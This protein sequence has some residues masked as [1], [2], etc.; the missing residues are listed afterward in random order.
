[1]NLKSLKIKPLIL[2][3]ILFH[4]A[5]A[6]ASWF[7]FYLSAKNPELIYHSLKSYFIP[8]DI[9]S[10]LAK[11]NWAELLDNPYWHISFKQLKINKFLKVFQELAHWFIILV[12]IT[13]LYL[14]FN[15]KRSQDNSI[16]S[17]RFKEIFIYAT[18]FSLIGVFS[19]PND[20]SD[21]YGY[22]ARGA[23]Q[24]F[25]G[26]NPYQSVAADIND[27]QNDSFLGNM[28]WEKNPA[29]Y[30]PLFIF[31]CKLIVSL[32]FNNF[33]LAIFLF[34]LISSGCFLGT[35]FFIK[36]IFKLENLHDRPKLFNTFEPSLVISFIALNPFLFYHSSWNG[37]NDIVMVFLFIASIYSL[38]K[39]R[40]NLALLLISA[41]IFIKYIAIVL[42]PL[43]I[44]YIWKDY[45]FID[46]TQKTPLSFRNLLKYLVPLGS[47]VSL[48]FAFLLF[49]YYD[50]FSSNFSAINQN[51]TLSHKSLF[52]TLETIYKA[53]TS[54][55]LAQIIKY[56][57]LS[58]FAAFAS[59]IYIKFWTK[60]YSKDLEISME[61][62]D[63]RNRRLNYAFLESSTFILAALVLVASPKFHSWYLVI[64]LA[65]GF[66]SFPELAVIFSI[67]HL[68]SFTFI[69]QANIL[70][71][72]L[73]TVLPS[74]F[75]F[76]KSLQ[77]TKV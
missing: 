54:N 71:Y 34:K 46:K 18:V 7:V 77:N 38:F 26:E 57:F 21:I 14:I 50:F 4:A 5:I 59:F 2:S 76:L 63:D 43:I 44:I 35:V 19:I 73:M 1:M 60:N 30:G 61:Y 56:L 74:F 39:K 65:L 29:P 69:D 51:V 6:L 28:L 41:S 10:K 49:N 42:L 15:P 40:F 20:S 22:I 52:N 32:S 68:L 62:Y 25:Y 3:L 47:L 13:F 12:D 70:N 8:V 23:Q 72:I 16:S 9:S 11:A 36:K 53:I 55:E 75:Y 66:L 58:T 27:W 64:V 17:L 45:Y 37:H 67:S 24:V 48:I 31:I 33:W